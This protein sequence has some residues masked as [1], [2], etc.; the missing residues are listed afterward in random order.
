M[1]VEEKDSYV[2]REYFAINLKWYRFK[3]N[4]TQERLAELCNLTPKYISSLERGKFCPSL[5]K[6]QK[7][8]NALNVEAYELIKPI[9][10]ET[11]KDLPDKIDKKIGRTR[12]KKTKK[13][14]NL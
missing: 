6:L 12:L 1:N 4:Y 14:K 2:L 9:S 11:V 13:N 10:I 7:I 3:N 5:S 8:A